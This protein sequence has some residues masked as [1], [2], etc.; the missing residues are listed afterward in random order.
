VQHG[1]VVLTKVGLVDDDLRELAHL[2]LEDRLAGT[3]LAS[4]EVVDVD[5]PGGIGLGDLR[6]ALD[7][8]LAATPAAA[9]RERPRLWVDRSFAPKGAGTVVTGTLA[10]GALT[11]GDELVVLH[12]ER[13]RP[14]RV[15]HLQRLNVDV[16][17]IAPGNRVAVNLSGIEHREVRRGDALVRPGQWHRTTMVDASL[18]VLESLDRPV[19]RRGAYL[20][21]LG[22]GEHAVRLR[23]LDG[24]SVSPGST[25]AVRLHLPR[26][27]PLLPGDRFVLRDSG[28]GETVGG[29]EVLDVDPVRPAARA[30]P[31]RSVERVVAE[32]G[33]TEV[34]QLERLTGERRPPTLGRW[35]VA[36]E[37][38]DQARS[39]LRE[40]ITDAGE[41]GLD[42][43]A[44]DERDRAVLDGLADVAVDRGRAR[45]SSA[46]DPLA[47]HPFV[48]ALEQ[49]PFTPPPPVD[50][51][52]G[53]LRRLVQRGLVIEQDGVYFAPSAIDAAA[54]TVARLLADQ[55]QGIT[56]AEAREALGTSRK[57]AIPLLARLDATGVTR[58]RSDVR[59]AGPLLPAPTDQV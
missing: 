35:V 22:S 45:P 10:G 33:W 34:D 30:Q 58:R 21:Y 23:V 12:G 59:I 11:V 19:S 9:D 43:A 16:G 57:W 2:E 3:F 39:R 28:R 56:V 36:P 7:R 46:A 13:T 6:G 50:V 24:R 32:R 52:G 18:S 15:R 20:A 17:H 4:A 48:A 29:G 49:A 38:L 44:L 31:D 55:P 40:A 53:E 47:A 41:L 1:L 25:G 27:L 8:L 51:P 42:V 14:V 26:P 37:A 5:A 54:R